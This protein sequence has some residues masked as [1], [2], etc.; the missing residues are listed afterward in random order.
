MLK[1][2]PRYCNMTGFDK[3][4][5]DSFEPIDFRFEI[6]K[7]V[8]IPT[9]E[10]ESYDYYGVLSDVLI[11]PEKNIVVDLLYLGEIRCRDFED[12]SFEGQKLE[13]QD[14][15]PHN[16]IFHSENL[17]NMGTGHYR[18]R[19]KLESQRKFNLPRLSFAKEHIPDDVRTKYLTQ[20]DL[21]KGIASAINGSDDLEHILRNF[22]N[23]LFRST[24]GRDRRADYY[25]FDE[26]L[27]EYLSTG[28]VSGDCKAIS[29][30]TSGL[31]N[32][33]GLPARVVDGD[34][35]S[36]NDRTMDYDKTI[37]AY[38]G[39][40]VWS[41]VYVPINERNGFWIPIDPFGLGI[42]RDYPLGNEAY[43]YCRVGLP[44]FLDQNI[45]TAQLKITYE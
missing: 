22:H 13:H 25:I 10:D 31:I 19:T 11:V 34:I 4:K 45:K 12:W 5:S 2:N 9:K 6:G 26:L 1:I 21:P 27:Q 40:H 32:A 33:L 36:Q 17:V 23:T 44:K 15:P 14:Y 28:K 24:N 16:P 18:F 29:T 38:R 42:F 8:E 41:E 7:L 43:A 39:G 3:S 30:F 35:I 37:R 20:R